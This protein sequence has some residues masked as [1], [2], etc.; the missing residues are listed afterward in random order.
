[1]GFE[2]VSPFAE[3][4]G[5][6]GSFE[7]Y[8]HYPLQIPAVAASL[9]A[10]ESLLMG[11]SACSLWQ[12]L[13]RVSH[14]LSERSPSCASTPKTNGGQPAGFFERDGKDSLGPA[15]APRKA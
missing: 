6:G 9:G 13:S 3:V 7:L 8:S 14:P 10:F 11:S 1:M 4:V 5:S 2:G 15:V 12:S